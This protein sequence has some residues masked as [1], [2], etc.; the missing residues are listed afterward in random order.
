MASFC[1]RRRK[2]E[3]IGHPP[4]Y[5]QYPRMIPSCIP[6]QKQ[7]DYYPVAVSIQLRMNMN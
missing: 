4:V 1:Q 5:E 3:S 6:K 2:E 7:R